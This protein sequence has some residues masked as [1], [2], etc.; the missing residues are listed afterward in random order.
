VQS[1]CAR[2]RMGFT[3]REC[4]LYIENV[5]H[6]SVKC[7]TCSLCIKHILDV[8]YTLRMCSIHR[9]RLTH[10]SHVHCGSDAW[11]RFRDRMDERE[12]ILP[13]GNVFYVFNIYLLGAQ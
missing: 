1:S 9:E 2:E 7:V 6:I 3:P 12:C 5:S 4:V 10:M 11:V 8:F 13:K